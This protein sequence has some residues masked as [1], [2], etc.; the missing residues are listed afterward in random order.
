MVVEF[1]QVDL[2]FACWT[3]ETSVVTIAFVFRQSLQTLLDGA[4][5]V[6][7]LATVPDSVDGTRGQGVH[8]PLVHLPPACWACCQVFSASFTDDVS[9]K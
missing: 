8:L 5:K 7:E 4:A 3:G 2:F 6:F 9:L 1:L